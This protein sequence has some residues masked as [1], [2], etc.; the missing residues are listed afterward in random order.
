MPADEKKFK[1][2]TNPQGKEEIFD[3]WRKKYVVLTPE[4]WVRQ[5]FLLL[6]VEEKGY[7]RSLIAVEKSISV[8]RLSKRFDAVVYDHTGHP[9]MLIEFKAPSVA[10]SQK[11]MEQ[12]GRYN[13]HLKVN[14]LII[15]NG[16]QHYC[17]KIDHQNQTFTFLSEIP[18]YAQ[19]T[20]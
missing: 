2:R 8:N 17:C 12:A 11:T 18:H 9:A 4:E 10:L 1:I 6:L 13:L 3:Y 5:Q 16:A 19:L 15:S 14:F 7:P 20:D